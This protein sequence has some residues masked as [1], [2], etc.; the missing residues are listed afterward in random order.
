[1]PCYH[2]FSRAKRLITRDYGATGTAYCHFQ[3]FGSAVNIFLLAVFSHTFRKLSE[4]EQSKLLCCVVAF[5]ILIIIPQFSSKSK[6]FTATNP[7]PLNR[8]D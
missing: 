5:D 1:M 6:R 4:T 7:S 8:R 3:R 2:L